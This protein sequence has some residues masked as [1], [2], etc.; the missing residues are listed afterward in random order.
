MSTLQDLGVVLTKEQQRKITG[1]KVA[2]EV[3][4][5]GSVGTWQYSSVP[6]CAAVAQDVGLYCR[7]GQGVIAAGG[8]CSN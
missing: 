6:S 1:G 3:S 4:C 5:V 7:S 8:S 2:L